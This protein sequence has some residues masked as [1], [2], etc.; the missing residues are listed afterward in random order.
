MMLIVSVETTLAGFHLL[1]SIGRLTY[2]IDFGIINFCLRRK[3]QLFYIQTSEL[4]R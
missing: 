3:V 4:E 1:K 2:I